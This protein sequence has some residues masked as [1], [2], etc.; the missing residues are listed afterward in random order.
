M[1]TIIVNYTLTWHGHIGKVHVPVDT[2]LSVWLLLL[3]NINV[4]CG[5][6]YCGVSMFC[7]DVT[8]VQYQCSV[9]VLL[10]YSINVL[11]LCYCCTLSMFCVSVTAVQ[12]PRS[13]CL[14]LLYS[15]NVLCVCYCCTVSMFC[16]VVTAVQ[17]Q[18]TVIRWWG[19]GC[20]PSCGLPR[21]SGY[22]CLGRWCCLSGRCHLGHGQIPTT[23]TT[24]STWKNTGYIRCHH[25]K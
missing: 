5:C 16:V 1:A 7:V 10:L 13:V 17:Y 21:H 22:V 9:S 15:I 18:C 19:V 20:Q 6:Y 11:C 4:P 2:V 14:L 12:Y 25:T 24:G 23:G 8:A 3:Y